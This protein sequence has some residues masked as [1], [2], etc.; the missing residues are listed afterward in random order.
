MASTPFGVPLRELVADPQ[1]L[2]DDL[3]LLFGA[4]LEQSGVFS[5]DRLVEASACS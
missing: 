4:F 5:R 1:I 2:E 3:E